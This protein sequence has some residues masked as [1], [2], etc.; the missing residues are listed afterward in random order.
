MN[1]SGNEKTNEHV[2][3]QWI[4]KKLDVKKKKLSFTSISQE[5]KLFEPTNP[6]PHTLTHKVCNSCNSGWLSDID[7]SCKEF[8]EIMIEG[9]SPGKHLNPENVEKLKILIYKI[10]LNFFATGPKS[11]KEKKLS[12]YHDFYKTK[13]TPE[14]VFLFIS[15]F[16][17]AEKLSINHLDGWQKIHDN[18]E[19][20][21]NIS[22]FRFKF[23]LQLGEIAFVLCSTGDKNNIIV[24]D[25]RYLIPLSISRIHFIE[26][27]D[28]S[29]PCPEPIPDARATRFLYN[30]IRMVKGII[31]G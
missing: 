27:F 17:D 16:R 3:P 1:I 15:L 21:F 2:I 9:K 14:N 22:D 19:I 26:K 6:I 24:Y 4:I 13:S 11:F 29:T 5:F 28:H 30:S 31:F 23:Y 7:K 12:F 10:F 18:Q 20:N 8:L 25:D